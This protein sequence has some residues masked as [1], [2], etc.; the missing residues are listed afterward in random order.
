MGKLGNVVSPL[1][2]KQLPV[3]QL[4]T[5]CYVIAD[6]DAREAVI[7]DPGDDADF[8][9]SS[10]RDI[11]VEPRTIIATH[12]HFDHIL[13]AFEIQQAYHIPFLIHRRDEFLVKRMRET[14]HYFLQIEVVDPPPHIDGYL[15][16]HRQLRVGEH[17]IFIIETPGHTPG[18]ICL[19]FQE[20]SIMLTGDTIFADGSSGRTDFQYSSANQLQSS[21]RK[22]LDYPLETV[23]YPGHGQVTTIAQERIIHLS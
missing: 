22:I 23:L 12:G 16:N 19:Y 2:I 20:M 3:G 4:V 15:D 17:K 21:I 13:A 9:G 18:S 8:I 6:T 11:G 1:V 5:N 10:L 14:A 7:V